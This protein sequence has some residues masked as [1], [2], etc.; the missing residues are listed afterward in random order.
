MKADFRKLMELGTTAQTAMLMKHWEEPGH[1]EF[2]L[3]ELHGAVKEKMGQFEF[4]ITEKDPNLVELS[5]YSA[6]ACNLLYEVM[7]YCEKL[8]KI[9]DSKE[10]KN[11]VKEIIKDLAR[12]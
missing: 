3:M 1:D 4:E 6:E 7:W 10:R 9:K 2:T 8:M 5:I 11:N 12:D